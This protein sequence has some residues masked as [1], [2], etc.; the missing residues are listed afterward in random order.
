ETMENRLVVIRT[1]DVG[2]DKQAEYLDIPDEVNPIMGNR[3]IRL[4]LDRKRMFKAQIRA[5]YRASA[6]GNLAMMYPMITSEEELDE[7]E[8]IIRE[9]KAGLLEKE[10][11]FKEIPVGIMVETP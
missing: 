8:K 1:V 7:I 11:P 9:I 6:Y 10:I 3:G 2:A 4:C 5:I